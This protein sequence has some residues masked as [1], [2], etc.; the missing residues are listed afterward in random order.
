VQLQKELV[1]LKL[2]P[3]QL[4]LPKLLLPQLLP[5]QLLLPQ[6]LLPH[7]FSFQQS[8]GQDRQS[9]SHQ[10]HLSTKLC[11]IVQTYYQ[12]VDRSN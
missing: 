8:K 5:L 1:F 6:L 7:Q 4:L 11:R 2:L 9:C 10:M 12:S 3:S